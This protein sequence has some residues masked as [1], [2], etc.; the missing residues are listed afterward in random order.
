[1]KVSRLQLGVYNINGNQQPFCLYLFPLVASSSQNDQVAS[2][3]T[4]IYSP[5]YR[6]RDIDAIFFESSTDFIF[7]SGKIP[8]IYFDTPGY[9]FYERSGDI[10]LAARAVGETATRLGNHLLAEYCKYEKDNIISGMADRLL[11]DV[12]LLT[13]MFP[14]AEAEFEFYSVNSPSPRN[15]TSNIQSLQA[16][17]PTNNDNSLNQSSC[18]N[19]ISL[20]DGKKRMSFDTI[21]NSPENSNNNDIQY[22]PKLEEGITSPMETDRINSSIKQEQSYSRSDQSNPASPNHSNLSNHSGSPRS[23]NESTIDDDRLRKKRRVSIC[24]NKIKATNNPEVME[25][26]RNTLK[27]KQQQKAIIEARQQQQQ[28]LQQQNYVD[29]RHSVAGYGNMVSPRSNVSKQGA[30]DSR[31]ISS[32]SKRGSITRVNR[33]SRNLSVFTPPYNDP[34]FASPIISISRSAPS[35]QSITKQMQST[36]RLGFNNSNSNLAPISSISRSSPNRHSISTVPLSANSIFRTT[37]QVHSASTSASISGLIS[38]QNIDDTPTQSPKSSSTVTSPTL[39]LNSEQPTKESFIHIFDNLYDTVSNTH[40]LK[41]TL[42]DQIRKTAT[43]LQTLQASGSMIESLVRG[44]FREMQRETV[45]D[46]MALEKRIDRMEESMRHNTTMMNPSPPMETDRRLSGISNA[47]SEI[48]YSHRSSISSS[49]NQINLNENNDESSK[50]LSTTHVSPPLSARS[51]EETQPRDY[52]DML[53][54]LKAR[55]DSLERRMSVP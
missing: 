47:S 1:M 18:T 48:E 7:K 6:L 41:S 51:N 29:R 36:S 2:S 32:M 39:V 25:Q 19:L 30:W 3:R 16:G 45:Q 37:A 4:T 34:N 8:Q 55:L 53:S 54:A 46:L 15:Y 13:R 31:Q 42:E 12:P 49:F 14:P 38:P 33:N 11:N 28:M 35:R 43:L 20:I 40:S 52:Q 21:T 26:V 24:S 50:F 44:H 17:S 10:F 27:L 9:C 22:S 5:F 23:H